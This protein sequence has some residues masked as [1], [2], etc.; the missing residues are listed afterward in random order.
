MLVVAAFV[1][2]GVALSRMPKEAPA[3]RTAEVFS[4]LERHRAV[5]SDVHAEETPA[6]IN[7]QIVTPTATPTP[8]KP[9]VYA[10]PISRFKIPKISVDAPVETKN[11]LRDGTMESPSGPVPVAWY[12]FT[13]K[14]GMGGNAVFSGHLDY[15]RYGPAVFYNL[16]KLVK[17]DG[18]DVVLQ[19]GTVLQYE[20]TALQAWPV[21]LVP[22]REVLATTSTDVLTIIT[23]GGPFAGTAY[24]DRLVVRAARVGVLPGTQ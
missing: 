1:A 9:A 8:A 13:T 14:P 12:D 4:D 15:I 20:V 23:C 18:I 22:M 11:L 5:R 6:P 21:E 17:G 19:D 10:A 2:A 7:A 16:K 3:T 24:L